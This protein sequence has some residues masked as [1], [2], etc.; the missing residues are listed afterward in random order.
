MGHSSSICIVLSTYNGERFLAEQIDSIL[1]QTAQITRIHIRDDGSSDGTRAIIE[2]YASRYDFITYDFAPNIGW[3][4]SFIEALKTCPGYEWYAFSDQDDVWFPDKIECALNQLAK[5]Q[6]AGT[7][8][9]YAG[10]V[11]VSDA[12]LKPTC[13]FNRRP[14]DVYSKDYPRTMT[15]DEMAGGLTYVFNSSAKDLLIDFPAE[16]KV[17]HDRLLMLICRLYGHVAY[18]FSPKVYYRQHGANSIGSSGLE[19]KEILLRRPSEKISFAKHFANLLTT[20]E[21]QRQLICE[22]L[23]LINEQGYGCAA[24]ELEYVRLCALYKTSLLSKL[25]LLFSKNIGAYSRGQDL[26]LRFRILFS[27]Y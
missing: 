22:G 25:R 9:L 27:T 17:G 12:E 6:A 10:N 26:K 21:R 8:I 14:V 4:K 15:M 24:N 2:D 18:D 20:D 16:G 7:P 11:I 5:L 3:R 1:A 13:L 19:P 23:L